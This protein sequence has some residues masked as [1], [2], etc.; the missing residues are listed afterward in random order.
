[1]QRILVTSSL[2]ALAAATAL[3]G[4]ST[5]GTPSPRGDPTSAAPTSQNLHGAPH[6]TH[7]LHTTTFQN[8]PCSMLTP[9]QVQQLHTSIKMATKYAPDANSGS[10]PGCTW[11]GDTTETITAAVGLLTAGQGLSNIY[12]QK[13][14]Y[15]VFNPQPEIVGYPAVVAMTTDER[16]AG[17]C[18]LL[19]GVS[20]KL[21]LEVDVFVDIATNHTTPC[22]S[23]KQVAQ[24]A[25]ATIKGG[26]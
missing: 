16:S 18:S 25:V 4:C 5:D 22:V 19:V 14:T 10:G 17:S 8:D 12:A 21:A 6:V 20:D 7:P 3:T 2:L 15:M 24:A 9:Q 26:S 11:S 1:M 23:A 13:G